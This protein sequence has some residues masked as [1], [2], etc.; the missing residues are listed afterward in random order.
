MSQVIQLNVTAADLINIG[1]EMVRK[2]LNQTEVK[3]DVYPDHFT[4]KDKEDT[5]LS[6]TK[7]TS[8]SS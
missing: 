1:K 4:V 8:P 6:W 7:R 2:N 5:I 3:L